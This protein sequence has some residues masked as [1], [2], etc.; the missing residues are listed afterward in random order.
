MPDASTDTGTKPD[1]SSDV[2]ASGDGNTDATGNMDTGVDA[3]SGSQSTIDAT[4]PADSG[5]DVGPALSCDAGEGLQI[6][7]VPGLNGTGWIDR[8]TNCV[9]IEG[10]IYVVQDMPSEDRPVTLL[11]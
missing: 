7:S 10:A 9:G 4:G 1:A 2:S 11:Q 3:D 5:V 8:A 6:K